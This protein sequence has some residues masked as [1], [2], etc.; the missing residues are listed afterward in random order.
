MDSLMIRRLKHPIW[1]ATIASSLSSE[2][3]A[4]RPVDIELIHY[5]RILGK[6]NRGDDR[7]SLE[8]K[9]A[10]ALSGLERLE[11]SVFLGL[12]PRLLHTSHHAAPKG[13]RRVARG[14]R[15]LPA[16]GRRDP[17]NP[18]APKGRR[19]FASN[20][21]LPS[22]FQGLWDGGDRLSRGLALRASPGLH[23]FAPSGQKE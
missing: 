1:S 2:G 15:L 22:P 5:F 6:A 16:P 23:A 12:T 14:W 10:A 7:R 13:Q 11:G 18:G 9:P 4:R 20:D 8:R 21:E 19:Q 3:I 17:T